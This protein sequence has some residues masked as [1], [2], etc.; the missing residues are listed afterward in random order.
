MVEVNQ[1]REKEE[2]TALTEKVASLE[3]ENEDL[4]R[5]LQEAESRLAAQEVLARQ[6][7]ERCGVME[8]AIT[9]MYE[10]IQSVAVQFLLNS[11]EIIR[12]PQ[13]LF[14]FQFKLSRILYKLQVIPKDMEVVSK[15]MESVSK[16][17]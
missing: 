16:L 7:V 6:T 3:K 2:M 15:C 17:I 14:A 1:M 8:A 11:F 10:H 13:K 9:Q 4:R 12:V 5:M